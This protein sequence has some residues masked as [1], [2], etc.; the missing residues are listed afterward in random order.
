MPGFH[1]NFEISRIRCPLRLRGR[2]L[3]Y[4]PNDSQVSL[5]PDGSMLNLNL[6]FICCSKLIKRG[7]SPSSTTSKEVYVG[8]GFVG[9][10]M[11]IE[12]VQR[13]EF[14][15]ANVN[16]ELTCLNQHFRPTAGAA[17]MNCKTRFRLPIGRV[18]PESKMTQRGF[19]S[20]SI[21]GNFA[22]IALAGMFHHAW[23]CQFAKDKYTG[24]S[25]RSTPDARKHPPCQGTC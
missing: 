20:R 18:Q 1:F 17:F 5:V 25:S 6:S 16:I 9:N 2:S 7:T 11:T 3:S 14:E 10:S 12:R 13:V 23:Q 8:S 21:E 15:F 4:M 22:N 19:L 24:Y